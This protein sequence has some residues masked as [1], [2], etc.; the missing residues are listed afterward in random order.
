MDEHLERQYLEVELYEKIIVRERRKKI[1]LV[2]LAF[3]VFLFLSGIPVYQERFPKWDSLRA[4]KN[5]AVELEKLKTESLRLKKPLQF[6]VMDNGKIRIEQVSSCNPTAAGTRAVEVVLQ[7]K[8]WVHA[9]SKVMLM[10]ELDAK[11]MH[12]NMTTHQICFDPVSGVNAPKTK[13][14]FVV[15][16]VKDL[17]ES[18]MDR[19]SYVELETSSARISIN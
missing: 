8:N 1:I 11:K 5:I 17:A 2:V 16:P 7:E 3:A 10:K 6:T 13:K 4:A 12:L 15:V 14:V 18:R 9:D 19:A